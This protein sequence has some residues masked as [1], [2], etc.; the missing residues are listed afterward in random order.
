MTKKNPVLVLATL[1]SLTVVA[2]ALLGFVAEPAGASEY[3]RDGQSNYGNS[4][5][6]NSNYGRMRRLYNRFTGEHFYTTSTQEHDSLVKV[7][8]TS[9]GEGWTAPASGSPVYR[10]YNPYVP[11]GDHHY[12]TSA[13]ERA[14][15][16]AAGWRDEGTGWFSADT[17]GVP[18][19]RLYNPYAT[20]G[21][22]H[23]T[24]DASERDTLVRAGWRNE[25]IAWYGTK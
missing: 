11:G 7:G 21:T 12:T 10:L 8:W 1:L 23:Y 3:A 14:A 13:T 19:Y 25:G 20:T 2:A 5:Y 18:L 4:N 16:I 24:A 6:G 15:C 17:T 9:E 22:H